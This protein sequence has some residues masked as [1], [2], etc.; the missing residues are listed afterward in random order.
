VNPYTHPVFVP[1][2]LYR[3]F[4]ETTCKSDWVFKGL[5][6]LHQY[7]QTDAFQTEVVILFDLF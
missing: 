3:K 5:L 2:R 6:P 1:L 7:V 4:P